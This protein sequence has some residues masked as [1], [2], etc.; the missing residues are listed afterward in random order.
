MMRWVFTEDDPWS[1]TA[2]LITLWAP[3]IGFFL[4]ADLRSLRRKG[5]QHLSPIQSIP[6]AF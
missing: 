2:T 1:T 4:Q 5:L 3:S 6:T